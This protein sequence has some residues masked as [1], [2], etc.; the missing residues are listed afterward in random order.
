VRAAA[1]SC[2]GG[3]E[4]ALVDNGGAAVAACVTG[5]PT[6]DGASG[7]TAYCDVQEAIGGAKA[8]VAVKASAQAY[9][10][11]NI[12]RSVTVVGPG[13]M[14]PAAPTTPTAKINGGASPGITVGGTATV[15]LDGL[16]VTAPIA[17]DG[18]LCSNG[19]SGTSLAI[20]RSSVRGAMGFG[21]RSDTCNL[22][23]DGN[24]IGPLNSGGGMRLAS[25]TYILTNNMIFNSNAGSVGVR[26]DD[27]P[28][29][30]VFA[31]NTVANNGGGAPG[32]A[33]GINCN[34]PAV[35]QSSIVALNSLSAATGGSQ[36]AGSCMLT[37]VVTSG[38]VFVSATD[39]HLKTSDPASESANR[40]CCIDKLPA[41]TRPNAD[42]D[43][44]FTRRP[45][46]A[47]ADIGAHE[48]L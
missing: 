26:I 6:R 5:R 2:V 39:F 23:V 16:D 14:T 40:A 1:G 44:D 28:A 19:L 9:G 35:I 24:Y 17:G 38:P 21:V 37:D 46:G 48:A 27:S 34:V 4:A 33:G 30:S 15:I 41:P 7:A 11:V 20:R 10:A 13:P 31:F 47:A 43:L 8:Y 18:I 12:A 22:L 32:T 36:F 45:K 42:H 3:G 29:G 25:T